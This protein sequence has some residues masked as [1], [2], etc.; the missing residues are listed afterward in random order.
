MRLLVLLGLLASAGAFGQPGTL[1]PS[2]GTDGLVQQPGTSFID[3]AV[4]PEGGIAAVGVSEGEEPTLAVYDA[5]GSPVLR[6]RAGDAL[7]AALR[8]ARGGLIA[9][10]NVVFDPAGGLFVSGGFVDV[11]TS[12]LVLPFLARFTAEY[13][14]DP[15]FGGDGLV[16]FDGA[17]APEL[18]NDLLAGLPVAIAADGA[19]Y[20]AGVFGPPAPAV[21]RLGADGA[22]DEAFG[23]G[24]V[25]GVLLEDDEQGSAAPAGI[26]FDAAGRIV[27]GGAVVGTPQAQAEVLAVRLTPDGFP[28][29]SFDDDGAATVVS[30]AG[31]S[32]GV[33]AVLTDAGLVVGGY[34]MAAEDATAAFLVRLTETGGV[35]AG[36]G[37]GGFVSVPGP[38]GAA[39]SFGGLAEDAEG[40]LLLGA[41]AGVDADEGALV[42]RFLPS[43]VADA[44]FGEGG[45]AALGIGS[46]AAPFAIAL[47]GPNA[48]VSGIAADVEGGNEFGF[49]ARVVGEGQ[50]SV[51]GAAPAPALTVEAPYP[52]P[53][54][55]TAWV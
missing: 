21:V 53:T 23:V 30:E 39:L 9:Y 3:V 26:A 29:A 5:D 44:T 35:D 36:F 43:G 42:F 12:S 16:F 7:A 1:D 38:A 10:T 31:F 20:V 45:V 47:Q 40:R 48:L 4:G 22:V 49:I 25:G 33:S 2:F 19:V 51:A 6:A 54:T 8:S 37:S 11:E 55:G 18:T 46:G 15:A 14:L 17:E 34:E 24:G 41:A 32:V 27:L 13:D 52:N 28:D 50:A